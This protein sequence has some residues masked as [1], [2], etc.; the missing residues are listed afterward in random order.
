M[1]PTI[2]VQTTA[3]ATDNNNGATSITVTKPTG[4]AVGDLMVA[5][6]SFS[7]ETGSNPVIATAS[8]WAAAAT[9]SNTGMSASIQFKIADSADVAASNFTF[10]TSSGSGSP[11]AGILRCTGH[12]P[13]NTLEGSFGGSDVAPGT[14]NVISFSG[15][16]TVRVANC[17][18]VMAF[19]ASDT[20]GG[21]NGNTSGYTTTPSTT[22]TELYDHNGGGTQRILNAG[23]YGIN[24]GTSNITQFGANLSVNIDGHAGVIAIF[25]PNYPSTGTTALVASS[26]TLFNT[27]PRADTNVTNTPRNV[28]PTITAPN[29]RVLQPTVWTDQV[30]TTTTWTDRTK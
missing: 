6:I 29:G 8:G 5:V 21:T 18:V 4:L 13:A 3:F 11:A 22:F 17:L 24:T 7:R 26:P 2:T 1:N 30:K 16:G 23:A 10:S 12:S 27:S 20:S 28:S 25:R 14:D 9:Q 19:S 15:T